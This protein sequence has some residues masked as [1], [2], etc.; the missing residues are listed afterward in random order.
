MCFSPAASFVVSG[1]LATT[2]VAI[3]R[4]PIPKK[5]QTLASLPAIFAVQQLLEGFVW[6]YMHDPGPIRTASILGFQ[7]IAYLFWPM[8]VPLATL[9]AEAN[10]A[11]KKLISAT[12][13][14][15]TAA[16]LFFL[17]QMLTYP[18]NVVI[19][20]ECLQYQMY[21]PWQIGILYWLGANGALLFSS[22]PW[23]VTGGVAI[24]AGAVVAGLAYPFAIAS[25][26]CFFAAVA[27]L[28]VAAYVFRGKFATR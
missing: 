8:F 3:S 15:G 14:A 26:W 19:V 24:A 4:K 9:R 23:W 11:R 7:G 6:L 10:P 28:V 16:A 12:F 25:I 1:V 27:S 5:E 20:Q 17:V 22:N 18:A 13:V 21:M 2:A